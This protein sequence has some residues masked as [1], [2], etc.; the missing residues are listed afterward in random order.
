M[1]EA[2]RER[3]TSRSTVGSTPGWMLPSLAGVDDSA[4]LGVGPRGAGP[5]ADARVIV[6]ET[7]TLA[8]AGKGLIHALHV[9]L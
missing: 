5:G 6:G 9:R 2:C 3:M 4:D 7:G 8:T 1:F